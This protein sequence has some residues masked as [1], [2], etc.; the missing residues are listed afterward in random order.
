MGLNV[1]ND[2]AG[3]GSASVARSASMKAGGAAGVRGGKWESPRDRLVKIQSA[4]SGTT[5][6]EALK[7]LSAAHWD[8]DGAIRHLKVER[9]F[10]LGLASRD[11]CEMTLANCS[12]DVE[13]AGAALLGDADAGGVEEDRQPGSQLDLETTSAP[14]GRRQSYV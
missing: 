6:E 5:Q 8:V 9:V 3:A 12:W 10:R 4:V 13:A 14:S 11:Q 7:A 1:S 2:T